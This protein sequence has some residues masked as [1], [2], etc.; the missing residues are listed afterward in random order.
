MVL[1]DG[2][3]GFGP[4]QSTDRSE[5]SKA[6]STG[7]RVS[8]ASPKILKRGV[9]SRRESVEKDLKVRNFCVLCSSVVCDSYPV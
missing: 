5:R 1:S 4:T 8:T 7:S 2:S 9:T 6:K 3:G